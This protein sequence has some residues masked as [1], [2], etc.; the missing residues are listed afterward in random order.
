[1]RLEHFF[2]E[3]N[4]PFVIAEISQNHDGSLGQ[5]HAFIDMVADCGADAVKFQTHIAN[6]ESTKWEQFRVNFSYEDK[7][8]YDYWKRMEFT[9][10]QWAGLFN[11]ACQRGLEFLSSPFSGKAL[12]LLDSIGIS[13][14]KFGSGEIFN[15]ELLEAACNTGKP[16]LIST[17]LSTWKDIDAYVKKVKV[18]GNDLAL[19]QCVTAYPSSADMI[20][21][22]LIEEFRK[23]YD[24]I[25][26]ISDHSATIYPC[27]AAAALGA[28]IFEVHVT[29]SKYMFGPDVAASVI[30]EDLKR[31]VEGTHFIYRMHGCRTDLSERDNQRKA[32]YTMFSKS[33]YYVN[34]FPKGYVLTESDIMLKKPYYGDNQVEINDVVG[35]VLLHNVKKD[36]RVSAEDYNKFTVGGTEA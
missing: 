27:I 23:R 16:I 26:G 28:R 25:V 15:T 19:F 6:E 31:I 14:W 20:D 30:P 21:I 1:M 13:A 2:R 33:L 8:R 24:C 5:A 10:E 18:S 29:M 34:D 35:K 11:H 32:L 12:N 3:Q 4:T 36:D 7:T 22:S 17:G 9:E